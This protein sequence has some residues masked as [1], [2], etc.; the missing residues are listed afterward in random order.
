MVYNIIS[1]YYSSVTLSMDAG[2]LKQAWQVCYGQWRHFKN[3][4]TTT[5]MELPRLFENSSI[6]KVTVLYLH[7]ATS[8]KPKKTS[9]TRANMVEKT[10]LKSNHT[11][12]FTISKA[13]NVPELLRKA[14]SRD[15]HVYS[16]PVKVSP[17]SD[18]T[19]F[20]LDIE[21]R[22]LNIHNGKKLK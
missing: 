3:G 13:W 2:F 5:S 4:V 14:I 18:W 6:D 19:N 16:F 22:A 17:T 7:C 9:K 21:R 15:Y 8:S 12:M 11:N 10:N 1:I 20:S